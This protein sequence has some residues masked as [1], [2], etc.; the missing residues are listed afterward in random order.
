[1]SKAHEQPPGRLFPEKLPP[2]AILVDAQI[3]ELVASGLLIDRATFDESCLEAC[4][5]D[6]RI[7]QKG[8]LG[9]QGTEIDLSQK[10][11]LEINPGGY[12][13][14]ISLERVKIPNDI[15]VRINTKRSFS[16]EGIALLTGTQIDP[17]YEG[18]LLFGFYNASSRRVVLRARRPICSLVFEALGCEV[19]RPKPPDPDLLHGNFPDRFVNE[20]ANR[21]VLSWQQL[22]E[23]VKQIDSIATQILELQ[24]KYQNVVEPIKELTGNVDKLSV[25]VDKLSMTI[26][27]LG[28]HVSKLDTATAENARQVGEISKNVMVLIHEVGAVKKEGER[29]G[30]AD[31]SQAKEIRKVADA[32]ARF[33]VLVYIF[34]GLVMLVAG[35]LLKKY[36]FP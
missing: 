1:M 34:W 32:V 24:A 15:V 30:A 27:S 23:H 13:A 21:E 35:L 33:H 16:Y 7:G 25:D 29:L 11:G 6:V 9:G 3:R 31:A 22:S 2:G 8:I 17:G 19:S 10:G 14:V 4:S 5:Y 28:D 26:Q 20:M 36:V 18:H 12:A